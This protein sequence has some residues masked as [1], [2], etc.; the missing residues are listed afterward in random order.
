MYDD[1]RKNPHHETEADLHAY[2]KMYSD[3]IDT[4]SGG[5]LGDVVRN[6]HIVFTLCIAVC[7]RLQMPEIVLHPGT[8]VFGTGR[9]F[10][11]HLMVELKCGAWYNQDPKDVA[12]VV[13][14]LFA[15][16][17]ADPDLITG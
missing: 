3:A 10:A 9:D 4:I 14:M 6:S 5:T 2:R 8:C 11:L 1:Y 12:Q 13:G 7:S 16:V 17:S 15:S